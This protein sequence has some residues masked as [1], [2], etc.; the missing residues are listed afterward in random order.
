MCLSC[1]DAEKNAASACFTPNCH[2][3]SLRAL[4]YGPIGFEADRVHAVT[5][6][7]RKALTVLCGPHPTAIA[8]GAVTVRSWFDRIKAARQ[9]QLMRTE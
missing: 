8:D 7:L 2:E 9:Q 5:P 3:C 1:Q 6:E 4:A